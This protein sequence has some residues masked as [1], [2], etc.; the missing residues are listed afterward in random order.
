MDEHLE[1]ADVKQGSLYDS[2]MKHDEQSRGDGPGESGL[3]GLVN[4]DQDFLDAQKRSSA[5]SED[6]A[7]RDERPLPQR[8]F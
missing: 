6:N 2:D 8:E 3:G 7:K 5:A 1:S 4:K